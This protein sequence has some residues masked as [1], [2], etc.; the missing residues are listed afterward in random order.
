MERLEEIKA[1]VNA[2]STAERRFVTLLGKARAGE[3]GSQQLELFDWLCRADP[4][5]KVPPS[6]QNNLP[7][8]IQRLKDLLLD[9][10]HLLEKRHSMDAKLNAQLSE[11]ALLNQRGL[12]A[13]AQRR[14]KRTQVQAIEACRYDL[15]WRCVTITRK[16]MIE[17]GPVNLKQKLLELQQSEEDIL[18]ALL[19]LQKLRTRHDRMRSIAWRTIAKRDPGIEAEIKALIQDLPLEDLWQ[20]GPW[21]ERSLAGNILGMIALYEGQ[22]ATAFKHYRALAEAWIPQVAWQLDEA[23]LFMMICRNYQNACFFH[24]QGVKELEQNISILSSFSHLPPPQKLNHQYLLYTGRLALLLSQA[25]FD[26]LPAIQPEILNWIQKELPHIGEVKAIP[27]LYNFAVAE[28]LNENFSAANRLVQQILQLPN[29][30]VREDVRNFCRIFQVILHYELQDDNLNDYLI[31][32]GKRHFAKISA[33]DQFE[34]CVLNCLSKMSKASTP[35][36]TQTPLNLLLQEIDAL[37]NETKILGLME[38]RLW[39]QAKLTGERL[40]SVYKNAITV[41]K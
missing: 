7:K 2:L 11:I 24:S 9:V 1:W 41:E 16:T 20:S 27:L 22:H 31:R 4:S 6:L 29:R 30:E 3:A 10:W 25:H 12:L 5:E 35:S 8:L 18:A 17:S 23:P 40:P 36:E 26:L 28:F 15:A 13:S 37:L 33:E 34:R 32:S 19:N 38:T 21:L 39:V 14:L